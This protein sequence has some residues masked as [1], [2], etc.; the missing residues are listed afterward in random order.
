[1]WR[2]FLY[3][4]IGLGTVGLTAANGQHKI[5]YVADSDEP[6]NW[7]IYIM[8]DDGTN[9][10]RLTTNDSIDNHPTLYENTLVWTSNRTGDFELYK[11]NIADVEGTIQRLTYRDTIRGV[12]IPDRHPK[13][14]LGGS[15]VI[16]DAKTKKIINTSLVPSDRCSEPWRVKVDTTPLYEALWMRNTVTN[17]ADS[18]GVEIDPE[19][20]DVS[21]IWPDRG[22]YLDSI[23]VGHPCLSRDERHIVFSACLS[24]AS[25]DWE[26]YMMD[27]N[28][29]SPSNLRRITHGP[30]DIGPDPTN[31]I[32][33][34]AGASFSD[35][36][37]WILFNST[38]TPKGYS[39]IFKVDTCAR[40]II[41]L[42]DAIPLTGCRANAYIP[43]QYWR[44][45]I[46]YVSDLEAAG[47]SH[48]HLD[49]DLWKM[50]DDGSSKVN[51]TGDDPGDQTLEL[52]DEVGWFCGL[53]RVLTPDTKIPKI[54]LIGGLQIVRQM[55]LD[56]NYLPN[57]PD[58]ARRALYPKFWVA[59]DS[60]MTGTNPMYWMNVLHKMDDSTKWTEEVVINTLMPR[61]N[62][63]PIDSVPPGAITDL[64]ATPDT[65]YLGETIELNW[66]APGD[67]DTTGAATQYHIR[68]SR[69]D[70]LPTRHIWWLKPDKALDVSDSHPPGTLEG[71]GIVPQSAGT[72]YFAIKTADEVGWWSQ[73]S[74]Y[75][76]AVVLDTVQPSPPGWVEKAD[77][78]LG[79]KG[80][81][82][83]DGGCLAFSEESGNEYIYGFKGNNRCEFYKYDVAGNTWT[84]KE[85]IPVIGRS[86]RK[87]TV[88]KGAAMTAIGGKV[89]ATKGNN[90]LDF[91]EYDPGAD[92]WTQ[93]ADVPEG[94]KR[95]KEGADLEGLTDHDTD[96]VHLLKGSGTE[97]FYRYNTT[98]NTWQVLPDAPDGESGKPYKNGSCLAYNVHKDLIYALKASYNE[99]YRYVL[100][101][102]Y[103]RP[104]KD[105]PRIG[106]SG[107][108]KKVKDGAGLAYLGGKLLAQKGCNT[109]EFWCY[110]PET[111]TWTQKEDIPLGPMNKNVK[112]GGA[113]AASG[114]RL[115]ALKGNNTPE[116]YQY[117][118]GTVSSEQIAGSSSLLS[119]RYSLSTAPNPFTGA[120][121]IAYSLPR[122]SNITLKLYDVSGKLAFTLAQGRMSP[123]RYTSHIDA[124]KLARGIYMLRLEAGGYCATRK[125]IV[126]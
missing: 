56:P 106:R 107:K 62:F 76:R 98:N 6:N 97:E 120:T 47:D 80:K 84:A 111:D 9:R 113:L 119:T 24:G 81:N 17:P 117:T 44:D 52:G 61:L 38:R 42:R 102:N 67:D 8:N 4:I 94:E 74:N 72:Y 122:P 115:Y 73:V 45:C 58:P 92:R 35:S 93:K 26:V 41:P 29:T 108:K 64:R 126:E 55:K 33:M 114:D 87:K 14:S 7:D 37:P 91:W 112:G 43:T 118:P 103:W 1:M 11:A 75:A 90:T 20:A 39:M 95:V 79:P 19:L 5:T 12:R 85:S 69:R 25:D 63:D 2:V 86:A 51:L 123:G 66:K 16:F 53:P 13:A 88:K 34:S 70:T 22:E 101:S 71:Y 50:R 83:K 48:P 15:Q 82:V 32:M 110:D 49:M 27:L 68:Y 3:A 116:F 36:A 40:D 77:V 57:W 105:L 28:G 121:E 46:I 59:L 21:N 89:Y 54:W 60:H 96:Y 124:T 65:V 18:F 100:D 99:F 109:R 104:L 23:D 10:Q 125:L 30:T 78:P 31:R